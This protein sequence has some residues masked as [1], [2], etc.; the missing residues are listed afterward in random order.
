MKNEL[1]EPILA[2][3]ALASGRIYI[4]TREALYGI[5]TGA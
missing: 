2:T 1:G 5:G 3:P 4:R